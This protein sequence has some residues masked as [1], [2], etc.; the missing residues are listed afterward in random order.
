M[1]RPVPHLLQKGPRRVLGVRDLHA[2]VRPA[3]RLLLMLL[4]Q[5]L[6]AVGAEGAQ[7]VPHEQGAAGQ[8]Q[9]RLDA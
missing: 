8:Q 3:R 7:Q 1:H 9:Q 5:V 2:A 4:L 6:L